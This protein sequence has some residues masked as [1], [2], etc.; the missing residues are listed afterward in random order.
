MFKYLSIPFFIS[1]LT[2]GCV[3]TGDSSSVLLIS[4]GVS[5]YTLV[6]RDAS[7]QKMVYAG[8]ELS[9]YIQLATGVTLQL[10]HT[11]NPD[12]LSAYIQ[13]IVL[14]PDGQQSGILF[15]E[16]NG[17]L[18]IGGGNP[19][20]VLYGVYEF[21]EQYAGCLWLAPDSGSGA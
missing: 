4:N 3:D 9:K 11:E 5:D 16:K 10:L 21:L 19:D 1:L 6:V 13:L 2:L 17:N 7:Q 20:Y 12:T 8:E 14:P 15:E 18:T